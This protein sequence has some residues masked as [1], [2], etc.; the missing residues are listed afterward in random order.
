MSASGMV[1]EWDGIPEES[2]RE[3]LRQGELQLD[4]LLTASIAADQ[5][6][7]TLAGAFGAVAVGLF[8]AAISL[9]S[10]HHV[11]LGAVG[12]TGMLSI[13]ML[14]SSFLCA[15]TARP[16]PYHP[17]GYQPKFLIASAASTMWM[18]RYSVEDVQNRIEQ[19][20]ATLQRIAL[21]TVWGYLV[22][23]VSIISVGI[24]FVALRML[25][26]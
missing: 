11:D 19:N 10:A 25:D 22:A 13:A 5:R 17:A 9:A 18:L 23:V 6:A 24:V 1:W 26:F 16:R 3:L 4:T 20:R 12:C 21:L 2:V 14:V 7:M 15:Y 8:A